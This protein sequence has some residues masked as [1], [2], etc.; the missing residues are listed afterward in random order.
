MDELDLAEL[1]EMAGASVP[2]GS[3]YDINGDGVVAVQCHSWSGM[4]QTLSADLEPAPLPRRLTT[5]MRVMRTLLR[6]SRKTDRAP[7]PV[8]F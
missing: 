3:R 6:N 5:G 1:Q 2:A 8:H 4:H 7:R